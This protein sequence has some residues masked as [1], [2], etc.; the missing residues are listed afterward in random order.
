MPSMN[1]EGRQL[2]AENSVR[3]VNCD[4][5]QDFIYVNGFFFSGP[6]PG[7]GHLRAFPLQRGEEERE[8][9]AR[10]ARQVG[11]LKPNY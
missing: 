4:I 6:L 5:L 10:E 3:L 7:R 2:F 9:L 8:G 11:A 1:S